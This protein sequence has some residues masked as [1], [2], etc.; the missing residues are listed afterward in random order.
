MKRKR[1]VLALVALLTATLLLASSESGATATRQLRVGYVVGAGELPDRK[2][3]FGLPYDG[4]IRAVEAL[5]V[6]GRV[7]QVA[8]NQD[9]TGALSLLARQ[10]Y[11][12]I[13]M[14]V[15]DPEA[16]L[17]VARDFP[18]TRFL[19]PDLSVRS[20]SRRPK[21]VQGTV[22]RAEEAGYLAG[23][24]AAL[25]E[26][27]RP[28]RDVIASV[29]GYK[30]PGVDR[31]IVGYRLGA[32]RADPGI[33]TLNAYS[34]NFSN[35]TKCRTVAL[36][37][38]AKGAGAVLNVAGGCGFG[39]LEAAKE[40]GV[41]GIG[42]DVDQSFFGRHILT[43]AVSRVDVG[44]F[45]AIRRLVRGSFTTGGDT[46]FDLGNGGVGLGKVSPEVPASVRRQVDRV[47]RQIIAGKIRVPTVS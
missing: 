23:Y 46:V 39:A 32:K 3:L 33:V 45:A 44:V 37:Q 41:W 40:K 27:R 31:W 18:G 24:L 1:A 35:P 11:D 17:A 28:G 13:I 16:L 26:K 10:K 8:P 6:E 38:I 47:R 21:N 15:P 42:V 30:F 2:S 34:N 7:L 20:L 36:G 14:G 9:A 25:M 5:G 4:F 22:F 19:V 43:S 12:L 29:G